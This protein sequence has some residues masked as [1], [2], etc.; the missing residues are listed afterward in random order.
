MGDAAARLWYRSVVAF[1]GWYAFGYVTIQ[2]L[3]RFGV[4][5]PAVLII[6]YL[7]G[8]GLLA[9]VLRLIWRSDAT[10]RRPRRRDGRGRA[11]LPDLG[12]RGEARDVDADRGAAAAGD[13]RAPAQRSV[14]HLFRP[15][16]SPPSTTRPRPCRC[17]PG[18][19]SSTGPSASCCSSAACGCSPGAGASTM[20]PSPTRRTRCARFARG[21]LHAVVILLVAD[22]LWQL[23]STAIDR[24]IAHVGHGR[25]PRPRDRSRTSRRRR[26]GAAPACARCCR[27]CASCCSPCSR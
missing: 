25:R 23:A 17:R 11:D 26:S 6:A 10:S 5:E 19:S 15:E 1:V 27:S 24:Q 14:E 18:R 9:I 4:G 21:A 2:L 12:R 3:R 7:L 13:A 22:L 16:A 8:L 20:A